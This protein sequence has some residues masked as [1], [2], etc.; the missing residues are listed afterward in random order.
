[1]TKDTER[2]LGKILANQ[3]NLEKM[4]ERHFEEDRLLARRV[5]KIESKLTWFAGVGATLGVLWV[6]A[7]DFISRAVG[8]K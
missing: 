4:L 3:E 8:L 6:I 2:L 7:G 1:M 5:Y